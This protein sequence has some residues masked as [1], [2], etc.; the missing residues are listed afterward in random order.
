MKEKY[1]KLKE[2]Y[3]KMNIIKNKLDITHYSPIT[4][5]Y[6]YLLNIL[7]FSVVY[8]SFFSCSFKNDVE[9]TLSKSIYFSVV[10]VTTLGY[11]D[12]IPDLENSLLLFTIVL[13][14]LLGIMI[15]GLFLNSLSQR[16]SENR[17]RLVSINSANEYLQNNSSLTENFIIVNKVANLNTLN[18]IYKQYKYTL[19]DFFIKGQILKDIKFKESKL[20]GMKVE[21]SILN[22]VVF[23]EV[24]SD[25]S[26]ISGTTIKN[27]LFKNTSLDK[28][29]FNNSI[30]KT[31]I[32]EKSILTRA[33]FNNLNEV[34]NLT[35]NECDLE[36]ASFQNTKI[37]GGTF[38]KSKFNNVDFSNSVF[39]NVNLSDS[40]FN[41]CNFENAIF[42][43]VYYKKKVCE[44][45]KE[46]IELLES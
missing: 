9:L 40:I 29:N 25:S 28:I 17:A 27:C 26:V 20:Y 4:Y 11:G 45:L 19:Q 41:D 24:K 6:M 23:D 32:F 34:I 39:K 3:E 30:F 22:N 13:Q 14:V 7:F 16:L 36:S 38:K 1:L 37:Y 35:I 21:E 10:T 46:F 5:F 8:L 42:Q 12:I 43:G 15:I 31:T 2:Y 33:L 18:I 44:N